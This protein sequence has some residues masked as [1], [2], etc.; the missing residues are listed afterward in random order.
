MKGETMSRWDE[1]A[2]NDAVQSGKGPGEFG[3]KFIRGGYKKP[4]RDPILAHWI[5]R[6]PASKINKEYKRNKKEILKVT[7]YIYAVI[8]VLVVGLFWLA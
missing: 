2:Q 3:S 1:K 6:S 4:D 7:W 5:A 8:I